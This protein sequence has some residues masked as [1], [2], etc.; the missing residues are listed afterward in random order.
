MIKKGNSMITLF[1][2]TTDEKRTRTQ[3][4]NA[5]KHDD[6]TKLHKSAVRGMA[7]GGLSGAVLGTGVLGPL[8]TAVGTPIGAAVGGIANPIVQHLSNKYSQYR[9]NTKAN[10]EDNKADIK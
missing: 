3:I 4:N 7:I 5:L 1:E 2:L 10:L 6:T 8:G 9:R